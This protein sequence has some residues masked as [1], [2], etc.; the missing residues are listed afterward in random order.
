MSVSENSVPVGYGTIGGLL[1]TVGSIAGGLILLLV[2]KTPAEKDAG[3]KLLSQAAPVAA[4]GTII[5]R[6]IQ[7]KPGVVKAVEDALPAP[8][9]ELADEGLR[10][11]ASSPD[12]V[13]GPHVADSGAV[14]LPAPAPAPAPPAA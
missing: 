10:L 13:D 2:G 14:P 4:V 11:V 5:S 3:V 8:L 1:A 12:G 6:G 7:A 9:R